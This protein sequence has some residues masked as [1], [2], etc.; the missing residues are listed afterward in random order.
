MAAPVRVALY[1]IVVGVYLCAFGA[2]ILGA[3][4]SFGWLSF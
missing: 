1:V 2:V 3:Q 4:A